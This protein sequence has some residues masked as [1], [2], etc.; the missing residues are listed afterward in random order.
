VARK[1]V[2]ILWAFPDVK[3]RSFYSIINILSAEIFYTTR[4]TSYSKALDMQIDQFAIRTLPQFNIS[5]K[6]DSIW[7][8]ALDT[9]D[10]VSRNQFIFCRSLKP[11]HSRYINCIH[12][13]IT[14]QGADCSYLTRK[15]QSAPR[16]SLSRVNVNGVLIWY[17]AG[18]RVT[19]YRNNLA[20]PIIHESSAKPGCLLI[21]SSYE[22]VLINGI[23][24]F[25]KEAFGARS[26][27]F[28]NKKHPNIFVK[29]ILGVLEELPTALP[30]LKINGTLLPMKIE[31]QP[32]TLPM[33]W[34]IGI[35]GGL[36]SSIYPIIAAVVGIYCLCKFRG[37]CK[38][39]PENGS[40]KFQQ[41]AEAKVDI[42][43]GTPKSLP[44]NMELIHSLPKEVVASTQQLLPG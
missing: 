18:S 13:L 44:S 34:G 41:G 27:I 38:R 20:H 15:V 11:L 40:A 25:Q 17:S 42:N 21:G 19:A 24:V 28:V 14:G 30:D 9:G 31:I 43:L 2:R 35:W 8:K 37:F 12:S 16:F 1:K 6:N 29:R 39:T 36:L 23:K 32:R 3:K 7:S 26:L 5:A 33:H 22:S 10:C 4:N